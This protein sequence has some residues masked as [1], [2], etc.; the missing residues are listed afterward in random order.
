MPRSN[1]VP[2]HDFNGAGKPLFH[3]SESAARGMLDRGTAYKLSGDPLRI[4]FSNP[5]REHRRSQIDIERLRPDES[6][7]MPPRVVE[8]FAS[9]SA[10]AAQIVKTYGC[11]IIRVK[12]VG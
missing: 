12:E 6:L 3:T 11:P 8:S 10:R 7:T 9:G 4:A 2:V 1:K 5:E